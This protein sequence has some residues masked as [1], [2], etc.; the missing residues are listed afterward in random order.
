MLSEKEQA[1]KVFWSEHLS[2]VTS[3][4]SSGAFWQ[5]L[6]G[7]RS[8]AQLIMA[9]SMANINQILASVRDV[10]FNGLP[11]ALPVALETS[12]GQLLVVKFE[13][14]LIADNSVKGSV[15]LLSTVD[16][17][18]ESLAVVEHLLDDPSRGIMITSKNHEVLFANTRL[19]Y[20]HNVSIVSIVGRDIADTPLFQSDEKHIKAFKGMIELLGVWKGAMIT[21][22]RESEVHLETVRVKRL[23]LSDNSLMYV[24]S[25]FGQQHSAAEDTS[26]IKDIKLV[27]GEILDE[28]AFRHS[29]SKLSKKGGKHI[30]LSFKP[31]F[32][33]ELERQSRNKVLSALKSFHEMDSF[34]YLGRNTFVVLITIRQDDINELRTVNVRIKQF[35]KGLRK[36]L[37]D[38]LVNDI[39]DGQIGVALHGFNRANMDEVISQSVQ[40]MYLHDSSSSSVN[41]Y[42][43]KMVQANIR[44]RRLEQLLIDAIR[45]NGIDVHFQPIVDIK[46]SQVVKLEALCRFSFKDV[47]YTVQ[48][49]IH[50]AE[51]L[52]LISKL[53]LIVAER[54]ISEFVEIK[55]V[56]PYKL[57]LSLNCSLADS[58]KHYTHLEELF[59]LVDNSP[60]ENSE[61]TIEI[62]ET[63][64]FEN[65]FNNSNLLERIRA[66][67][68]KIAVDDFGTGNSSFSYFSD[69]H[70]DEL[71]IDRKFISDIDAIKQKYFAVNM[72]R[73][74]SHDLDIKV[75]AEGVEK[76][77][78]LE[79]L[80]SI[81]VDYI[82]GYFFYR[83]MSAGQ[84]RQELKYPLR[85]QT[86]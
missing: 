35:F 59:K 63:A 43:E 78:E 66:A 58:G 41:F 25:F 27:S 33:S 80:K 3:S 75:V 81:D 71:K 6:L 72:L 15:Q 47:S 54:A 11:T 86:H 10:Q 8:D 14:Y 67:G 68:V 24:Y 4:V 37:D 42:D 48:E 50:L 23:A 49:M 82:Q 26:N 60:L 36:Y 29:A 28:V 13:I 9:P 62:T 52:N 34:G 76:A 31:R 22:S 30:I 57:D 20:E 18:T 85:T 74:L 65:N 1:D 51:E 2:E 21:H 44:K 53:D 45:N 5:N 55:Q 64:Y 84:I 17:N 7:F 40:A 16:R 73:Q 69:F 46:T 38:H 61:V 77:S 32:Y 56:V 83:P 79:T 70:F 12:R 39:A 19:C